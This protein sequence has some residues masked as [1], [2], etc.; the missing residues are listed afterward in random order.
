MFTGKQCEFQMYGNTV[1]SAEF[2]GSDVD[3]LNFLVNKL[4]TPT[5][6]IA[7][8]ILRTSDIISFSIP[9]ADSLPK[10]QWKNNMICVYII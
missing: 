10:S 4:Q 8:A 7:H 9:N 3:V 5:G 6:L 2:G 1:V